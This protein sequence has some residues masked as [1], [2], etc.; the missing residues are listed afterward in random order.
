MAAPTC[1]IPSK[2]IGGSIPLLFIISALTACRAAGTGV[3][4][5]KIEQIGVGDSVLTAADKLAAGGTLAFFC[6]SDKRPACPGGFKTAT[7][8]P[9]KLREL[10]RQYPGPLIGV[11][12]GTVCGFDVL[13]L[14][15]RHPEAREW[16]SENRS[17]LPRTRA[18]RTRSGGLH[19][20]F[21]HDDTVHCTAGKIALGVDTRGAGGYVIWWPSAGFPVLS[22][23]ALA[24]WPDWLLVEFRPKPKPTSSVAD[25]HAGDGWLRGLVRTVAT[26]AEGERNSILFWAAC[27]GGEAVRDGKAAEAFVVDVLVEA[28][29]HAG[30]PE[31]EAHRTIQSGMQRT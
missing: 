20:L 6:L 14:D 8:D 9:E 7:S 29:K 1:S 28:A 22:D 21:R 11:P 17:R 26:A 10:W 27:R 3:V 13:D 4:V 2:H 18:H 25:F 24:P 5:M 31:P 12:T 16:Y 19:L 30:L 15:P 23:A